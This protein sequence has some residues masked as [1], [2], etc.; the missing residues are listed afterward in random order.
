MQTDDLSPWL[1]RGVYLFGCALILTAAIDLLSTAWPLRPGEMT[2]RYGFFGLSA[3][4]LQTPTLG[5]MLIMGASIVER[6]PLVLRIT[7]G[8]FLATAVILIGVMGIFALDVVQ[9]RG[10]RPEEAQGTVLVGGVLQE[11]K[12]VVATC[13]F[14][15]LGYGALRTGRVL[16]EQEARRPREPGIVAAAGKDDG[17]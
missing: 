3:G 15:L 4:Y 16:A 8:I 7:A 14:A 10:L 2:W 17:D 12:Y 6:R 9:V 11:V 13:V 1:I 5:L